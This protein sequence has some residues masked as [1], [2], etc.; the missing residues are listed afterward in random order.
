MRKRV[1]PTIL[2]GIILISLIPIFAVSIYAHPT[3]DD[4]TYGLFVRRAVEQGGNIL[5]VIKAACATAAEY[6]R[7]WQG[8]FTASFIFALQPGGFSYDYIS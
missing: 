8:T 7:S 1:L 4:F 3:F 2:I 6:Y 5:D